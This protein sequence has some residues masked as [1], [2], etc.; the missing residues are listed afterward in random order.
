M[1]FIARVEGLGTGF[2]KQSNQ[3]ELEGPDGMIDFGLIQKVCEAVQDMAADSKTRMFDNLRAY[4]DIEFDRMKNIISHTE[5]EENFTIRRK[6]VCRYLLIMFCHDFLWESDQ[7]SQLNVAYVNYL[8]DLIEKDDSHLLALTNTMTKEEILKPIETF[9]NSIAL[10]VIMSDQSRISKEVIICCSIL[11]YLHRSNQAKLRVERKEFVNETVS[12][13]LNLNIIATQYYNYKNA[14]KAQRPFL[15]LDYPWLFST[16]AKVDVLQVENACSQN[17]QVMNQITQG[18]NS[19]NLSALFN[20]QNVH[21][22]IT[23]RRDRILED[24]LNKLSNQGKNLKKP[25]KVSFFGEAGVDAGG[26]R[27]EFFGLLT[28]ELFNPAYAM[29]TTKNVIEI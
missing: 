11:D 5:L 14:P 28:K 1:R 19:G 2:V 4:R 21:L 29:F 17:T 22:A 20:M 9:E 18:L 6:L 13:N 3:M 8:F 23:V 26:V 27:K 7:L 16:E 25:L 24:S 12:N 15:I 10:Q